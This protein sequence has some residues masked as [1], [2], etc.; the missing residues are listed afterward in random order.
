MIGKTSILAYISEAD[1]L[2]VLQK[3]VI[4]RS[5]E[6]FAIKRDLSRC[7]IGLP[8]DPTHRK[9]SLKLSNNTTLNLEVVQLV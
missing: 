6:Q 8:P 3:T 1:A 5:E 2:H 7:K 4:D 9:E